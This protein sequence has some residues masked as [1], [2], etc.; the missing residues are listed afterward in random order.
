MTRCTIDAVGD[1]NGVPLYQSSNMD[2]ALNYLKEGTEVGTIGQPLEGAQEVL[3]VLTGQTGWVHSNNLDCSVL[4]AATSSTDYTLNIAMDQ[5]TVN[6]LDNGKFILYAFKAVHAVANAVPVVWFKTTSLGLQTSIIWKENYQAY[7][8]SSEDIPNGRIETSNSYNI[9]LEQTLE[10][11]ND[12]GTGT[13]TPWGTP[14][15]I[16]IDNKTTTKFTCGISQM[17]AKTNEFS[18]ICAIPLYGRT[19]NIISPIQKVLLIFSTLPVNTGTVVYQ[20]F[21]DA[22]FVDMTGES[23]RTVSYKMNHG[24]TPEI[25]AEILPYETD[26]TEYLIAKADSFSSLVESSL[27]PEYHHSK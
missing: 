16:V 9:S 6:E 5:D 23:Q 17:K 3:V 7:T 21:S 20:A 24:W 14:D 18:P 26:I 19:N 13:L 27:D 15:A 8:A 11:T 25:W 4:R 1:P 10:V 22:L 2:H 12:N